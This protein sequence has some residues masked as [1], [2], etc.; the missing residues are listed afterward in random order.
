VAFQHRQQALAVGRVAGFDDEVEDQSASA[1]GEIE[2]VAVVDVAAALDD[3]VGMRLEQA[4][5]LLAGR[6]RI[7]RPGPA[8]RSGR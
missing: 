3:D 1:G 8:V 7:P 6:N 5:Q 2:F 4:Y